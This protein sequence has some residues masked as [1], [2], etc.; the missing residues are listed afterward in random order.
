VI[1]DFT[2]R[3]PGRGW[4]RDGAAATEIGSRPGLGAKITGLTLRLR[5]VR[6]TEFQVPTSSF[7]ARL[8]AFKLAAAAGR[9]TVTR[10][11]SHC[12]KFPAPRRVRNLNSRAVDWEVIIESGSVSSHPSY[13]EHRVIFN[14]AREPHSTWRL[15]S[16]PDR[17]LA[18]QSLAARGL[19]GSA[20][21]SSSWNGS[22]GLLVGLGPRATGTM[23]M[24]TPRSLMDSAGGESGSVTVTAAHVQAQAD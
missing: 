1:H 20:G 17:P 13:S 24:F 18:A 16:P 5:P 9:A 22:G 21:G 11:S 2:R 19:P 10:P 14:R 15:Q 4:R 6:M 8:V 3:S 12:F 7:H 23:I